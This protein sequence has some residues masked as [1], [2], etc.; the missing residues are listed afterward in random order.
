MYIFGG[1]EEHTDQFS[2]DVH[3]L[4][5]KSM[6]WSYVRTKVSYLYFENLYICIR[7]NS[8]LFYR[9]NRR[10]IVTSI[11]LRRLITTCIFSVDVET[12]DRTTHEYNVFVY[13]KKKGSY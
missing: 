4:D 11:Q 13:N 12:P 3:K 8:F 7:H 10:A 9:E 1:Y 2:Q 5:L 6:E